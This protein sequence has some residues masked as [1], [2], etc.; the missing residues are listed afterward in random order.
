M[1]TCIISNI[2]FEPFTYQLNITDNPDGTDVNYIA[3]N[4]YNEFSDR[5]AKA[6]YIVVFLN[7]EEFLPNIYNDVFAGKYTFD[8]VVD[9]IKRKSEAL[10]AFIKNH[11]NACV[12]WFGMEDY[13]FQQH[14]VLGN[15]P[16]LEYN[17][18]AINY[19]VLHM[20]NSMDIFID[21][22]RIIALVGIDNA[23][24]IK[25]KHRW[26][27]PY[28]KELLKRIGQELKKQKLIHQGISKKCIVLDCDNT[29]WGGIL[30]EDG[31]GG[32][33][34]D[35]TGVGRQ[36]YEFQRYLV[37]L[38]NHG[39]ILA[40]CSKNDECDVIKVFS[41]HDG[42]LLKE[43]HI[44]C[45][46]CNWDDKVKNIIDISRT[47]NI[48]LNSMVFVDDSPFEIELVR[49]RLPDV[50]VY[51]YDRNSIYNELQ[52]FN[53][54][55]NTDI[56]TV[57]NRTQTYKSNVKRKELESTCNS[58]DEYLASLNM[59]VDFHRAV[60]AE[61]DRIAELTQRTNKCTNGRRYTMTEVE[62]LSNN[63]SY[64]LYSINV[65]DVFADYGI[66]GVIGILDN[67][68]DVFSLS[69][70][71][72]GRNIEHKMLNFIMEK[73]ISQAF[74]MLSEK[75]EGLMQLFGEYNINTEQIMDR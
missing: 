43:Q 52:C 61:F 54:R 34:V 10:Y 71:A 68:V 22:K 29:I 15:V 66:V 53:L 37:T 33:K 18:D 36:Y 51:C 21:L 7:Y 40:I 46:K 70:R 56:K 28:S 11:S 69:C 60:P 3:Y 25:C 50:T 65:K 48:D 59:M 41:E 12:I 63:S 47:L 64:Q 1:S 4:E 6:K 5:M 30:S 26:H 72:L 44:S 20:L 57:E 16:F 73:N 24:D 62:S 42:M 27:A 13:C 49:Q 38:Y 58:I 17:V 55:K 74:F 9:D 23:Y 67:C 14:Y 2:I 19:S 32:I 35:V 39:V 8:M 75:N 31:I 45:F